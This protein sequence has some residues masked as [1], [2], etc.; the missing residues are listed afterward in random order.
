MITLT[1][2][3]GFIGKH[4]SF[5]NERIDIKT[6]H[7]ICDLK[8]VASDVV[9]HLAAVSSIP[10][11]FEN[12]E[13]TMRTNLVGLARV[14]DICKKKNA[15]LIFASSCS[16]VEPLS[17]YAYS[18]LWGEELIKMS[19]VDH[20]ILRFGNVYGEGDDKSAIYHFAN[21][22]EITIFGDG[23]IVRSFI[24]VGD[25]VQAI[26]YYA[27]TTHQGTFNIGNEN[28]TIN[29]VAG[30]FDKEITYAD[31]RAGDAQDTSFNS[32]WKCNQSLKGWVRK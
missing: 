1:G 18:K 29:E 5:A 3:E 31:E 23:S 24:Y 30:Y 25:L 20:A 12:T 32:D 6:G 27:S 7:D 14:I 28:L 15:R 21:D 2:A 8:D 26:D 11:S 9:V 22:K 17:P 19:G 4:I 10:A 16:V 13:E